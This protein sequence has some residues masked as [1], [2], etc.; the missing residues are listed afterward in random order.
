L[1]G[2]LISP[3][4]VRGCKGIEVHGGGSTTADSAEVWCVLHVLIG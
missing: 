2:A 1:D 4:Q 3:V